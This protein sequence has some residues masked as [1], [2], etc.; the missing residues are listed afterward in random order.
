MTSFWG[1]NWRRVRNYTSE[2]AGKIART[3][4]VA[5]AGIAGSLI[6]GCG[7]ICGVAAAGATDVL[8]GGPI[9]RTAGR[10][11]KRTASEVQAWFDDPESGPAPPQL[12]SELSGARGTARSLGNVGRFDPA[13]E[14]Q[15]E[16]TTTT[17]APIV[18]GIAATG[19]ALYAL[20]R[21]T[22]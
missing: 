14:G 13:Q 10:A 11:S 6:P 3:G 9:E 20:Y 17:A 1:R 15:P 19:L 7:P 8:L 18:A 12:V 21:A 5:T 2:N 22:R 4:A 16:K